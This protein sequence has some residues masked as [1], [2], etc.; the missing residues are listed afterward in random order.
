MSNSLF[1]CSRRFIYL[2]F[3]CSIILLTLQGFEDLIGYWSFCVIPCIISIL[4]IPA[5]TY[6]LILTSCPKIDSFSFGLFQICS[7][8][9]SIF[10]GLF[11]LLASLRVDKMISSSWC[12]IFISLWY[13]LLFY[14]V[15]CIFMFPGLN[16]VGME[17]E[18]WLM[19]AWGV[20][21]TSTCIL[22][23]IWID[24][25]LE[26]EWN[27]LIPIT[28]V[29]TCST[30]LYSIYIINGKASLGKEGLLYI[31][32]YALII[33]RIFDASLWIFPLLG[34]FVL[35]DW[36]YSEYQSRTKYEEI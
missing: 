17:R 26:N 32:T 3:I 10:I 20:G 23:P 31:L 6:L 22:I 27:T 7:C 14:F 21:I 36:V 18:A 1:T 16:S 30:L 34:I 12:S 33:T 35:A 25:N 19:L 28:I 15:V 2:G 24:M 8:N 5:Y 29:C 13:P 4:L 9:M 11:I